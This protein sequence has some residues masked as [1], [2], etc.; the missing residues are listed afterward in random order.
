MNGLLMQGWQWL[1]PVSLTL[2]ALALILLWRQARQFKSG[3]ELS[4]R[5]ELLED[6]LSALRREL[7]GLRE[8]EPKIRPPE[9]APQETAY[10]QA[11][12]LAQQGLDSSAV[13]LGCGISRGEAELIVALYRAAPRL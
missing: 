2:V 5:L 6:Q 11:M 10:S 1:L 12:R 7:A 13:A 3:D 4:Q 9:Q 8:T